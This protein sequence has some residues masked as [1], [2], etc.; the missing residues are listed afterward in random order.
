RDVTQ[1]SVELT[2]TEK[3]WGIL[4]GVLQTIAEAFHFD[5]D[6]MMRAIINNNNKELN[7]VRR[8]FEALQLAA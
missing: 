4:M 1:A 7:A 2:V 3:I 5:K 6:E 8:A